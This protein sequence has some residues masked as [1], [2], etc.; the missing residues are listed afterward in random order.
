MTQLGAPGLREAGAVFIDLWYHIKP[1]EPLPC[2]G[3]ALEK[4]ICRKNCKKQQYCLLSWLYSTGWPP[5]RC[6]YLTGSYLQIV[7]LPGRHVIVRLSGPHGEQVCHECGEAGGQAGLREMRQN[8]AKVGTEENVQKC[9]KREKIFIKII[10][11][12][13]S[14][15]KMNC[16]LT[17]KLLRYF[18]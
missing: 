1:R 2:V 10:L 6:N 4:K 18:P 5:T 16:F 15:P 11:K 14:F 3:K 7:L 13:Y 17:Q 9:K 8:V 12:I